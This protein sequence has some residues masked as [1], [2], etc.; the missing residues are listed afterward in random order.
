MDINEIVI[1][2]PIDKEMIEEQ[3]YNI[4]IKYFG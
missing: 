3:L 4:F 2:K 1:E